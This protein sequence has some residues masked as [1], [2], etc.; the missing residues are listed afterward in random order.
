[1]LNDLQVWPAYE[2]ATLTLLH[3]ERSKLYAILA[4]LKAKRLT[5]LALYRAK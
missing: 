1:M 3:S 4:F 2:L 5:T